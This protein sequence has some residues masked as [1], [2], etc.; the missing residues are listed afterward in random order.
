VPGSGYQL[1]AKFLNDSSSPSCPLLAPAV[2]AVPVSLQNAAPYPALEMSSASALS[3]SFDLGDCSRLIGECQALLLRSL[4]LSLCLSL[5][6][7]VCLCLSVSLSLSLSLSVLPSSF[8]FLCRDCSLPPQFIELILQK[9]GVVADGEDEEPWYRSKQ[10]AL[11]VLIE[12]LHS[13]V[14]KIAL[15]KWKPVHPSPSLLFCSLSL[16]RR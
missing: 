10:E 9:V 2:V 12:H 4:D 6:L 15:S 8:S 13:P 14:G 16:L 11:G 3:H 7:S 5:C 1:L